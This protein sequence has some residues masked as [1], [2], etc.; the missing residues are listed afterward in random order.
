MPRSVCRCWRTQSCRQRCASA[1]RRPPRRYA[2]LARQPAASC[3]ARGH[4]AA[5]PPCRRSG[6]P[7]S[8]RPPG[9][10]RG[11]AADCASARRAAC[12][13]T[14]ETC[15]HYL[16]FAAE[17]IA[18]GRHARSSAR[19]RSARARSAKRCG[20][21][22][23]QG[24]IDLVATD[25]SPAPPALKHLDD[26]RL[27]GGV[28]RHRVAAARPGRGLD[29]ARARGVD[30]RMDR[31]L[32]VRR[33]PPGSPAS[34]ARKGESARRRRRR[35]RHL[36]S[37]R[38]NRRRPDAL[39][40]RHPVTPYD[41]R[42]LRGAW[43]R[44]D[45]AAATVVYDAGRAVGARSRVGRAAMSAITTHVLDTSAGG[46]R[47]DRRLPRTLA[48]APIVGNR[49]AR[50]DRSRRTAPGADAGSVAAPAAASTG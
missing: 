8:H 23:S 46:R 22:C 35:P 11:A 1:T 21:R 6:S 9:D 29:R 47:R 10:R 32:D 13:I 41:G 43:R 45:P 38:G 14:V 24:D 40:H 48:V 26:G 36:G 4:R 42:R 37:G 30:R 15:P 34:T 2:H 3:G 28:G 17:E 25:H 16:T 19:R 33:R 50:R 5:D 7:R 49:R 39:Y 31:A 12:A 27:R 18:D 20:R 44:T